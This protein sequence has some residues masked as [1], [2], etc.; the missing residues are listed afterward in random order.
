[1]E[2]F[3]KSLDNFITS[4]AK[5]NRVDEDAFQPWR[6]KLL[7]VL[8]GKCEVMFANENA[9]YHHFLCKDG[10][11]ELHKIQRDMV[12]TYADKSA[13]SRYFAVSRSISG[14]CGKKFTVTI[15]WQS[16]RQTRHCGTLTQLSVTW[17]GGQRYVHTVT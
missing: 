12:V 1:M 16:P 14:C 3:S 15:V 2:G 4:A 7:E 11:D 6:Q 5:R 10:F 17:W 13:C 9:P 8:Q